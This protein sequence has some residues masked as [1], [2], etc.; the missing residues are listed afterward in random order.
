MYTDTL[1]RIKNSLARGKERVKLPYSRFDL[2]VLDALSRVGYLDLVTRKGRGT[3]RI[4]EVKLKYREDGLPFISGIKFVSRP[5]RRIY[6]G[7]REIKKSRQGYGNYVLSTPQGI[8]TE[9][10]ARKKK[11]GGQVLFEIW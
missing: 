3:R 10:E 7:Y 4:I 6:T 2:E 9:G 1:I 8:M 11:V 5:S